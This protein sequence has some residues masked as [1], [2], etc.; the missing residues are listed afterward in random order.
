MHVRMAGTGEQVLLLHGLGVSGRYFMPLARVLA[1]NGRGHSRL[2]R[3]GAKRASRA[4]ARRRGRSRRACRVPRQ[5]SSARCAD[6][7]EL[8]RVPGGA[9][10]RGA[11]PRS[12]RAA[13][14]S[15]GRLSIPGTG[16]G[17]RCASR[18]PCGASRSA[19]TLAWAFEGSR[20]RRVRTL[21]DRPE[22]T[23]SPPSRHPFSWYAVS[24]T[25][26]QRPSGLP[27]A[28]LARRTGRSR[29]SGMPHTQPTSHIRLQSRAS[30]TTSSRN[31]RIALAS[32][33]ARSTIGTWL[34]SGITTNRALDS[35][36]SQAD[37]SSTGTTR[38]RAPETRRVGAAPASWR[39]ERAPPTRSLQARRAVGHPTTDRVSSSLRSRLRHALARRPRRG[40]LRRVVREKRA[41]GGDRADLLRLLRGLIRRAA[42]KEAHETEGGEDPHQQDAECSFRRRPLSRRETTV[43]P[44]PGSLGRPT[45]WRSWHVVRCQ[46]LRRRGI[47]LRRQSGTRGDN[48][49]DHNPLRAEPR[50]AP[51]RAGRGPGHVARWGS[52]R[53]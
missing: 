20:R 6:R 45:S 40:P 30:S 52:F 49:G 41:L 25:R 24:A 48:P 14:A 13:R 23:T 21:D 38:S 18:R 1:E 22:R 33:S 43:R 19:T 9:H 12:R 7:R 11:T 8:L 15:A 51:L 46:G 17:P 27:A 4:S 35:P 28:R 3:L 53:V 26:S 32:A 42:R 16:C 29:R 31:M 10:A 47:A 44:P 34:A 36:A 39:G 37:T 50:A 2:A 5:R